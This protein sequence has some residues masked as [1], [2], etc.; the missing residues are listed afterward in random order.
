MKPREEKP[1]EPDAGRE[2]LVSVIVPVYGV[3]AYLGSCVDGIRAQTYGHV[4][5]LL[6]D[7]GSP[8]GCPALCDAYAADDPRIRVIH[9]PNGGLSDARNAGLDAATGDL[10]AFVDSDDVV[11]PRML[12][13]L[14]SALQ[15]GGAQI[16]CC[17][18]WEFSEAG[19]LGVKGMQAN[20]VLDSHEAMVL[21]AR[22]KELQ[23]YVWNK[24]FDARLWD[25]V[26]FPVGQKYE[27]VSTTYKLIERSARVAVIA[28]PLYGYR[29]RDDS[30][31]G[32]RDVQGE[33]DCIK[34]HWDRYEVLAPAYPDAANILA[35]GAAKAV[36]NAW[37]LLWEHRLE[38]TR[39]QRALVQDCSRRIRQAMGDL[40]LA[41]ELGITGKVTLQLCR[42]PAAWSWLG[43]WALDRI[44]R[45]K[46]DG[47]G[48]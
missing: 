22:D 47:R 37:P 45:L 6:V 1:I 29:L 33:L 30:I 24:L 20:R 27:D 41:A 34:A 8:D 3:E 23:N 10:I 35:D 7:D 9:K 21:L 43:A 26:R 42:Y 38:L 46:H 44:Y 4:E 40:T 11:A 14:V 15:S 12:E 36:V 18:F 31:V 19:R 48:R 2:P 5:V 32:S 17:A 28:E 16:A 39:E 13:C 25:G